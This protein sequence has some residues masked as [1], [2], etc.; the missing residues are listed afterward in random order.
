MA[1]KRVTI[2]HPSVH[3]RPPAVIVVT[4]VEDVGGPGLDRHGLGG[5]DVID[6]GGADRRIDRPVS[7]RVVDHVQLGA[8]GLGGEASPGA[9]GRQPHSGSIDQVGG[10]AQ[11]AAQ[12]TMRLPRH[13]REQIGKHRG[14]SQC[15]GIG[16]CRTPRRCRAKVIEPRRV[17]AQSR[18]DLAKAR[19][20]RKLC[21]QQRQQLAFRRQPP[22]PRVGPVDLDKSIERG[23][24]NMLLQIMKDA[25]LMPHGVVP[26]SCPITSPTLEHE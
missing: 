10:L 1:L 9:G 12:A 19:G 21:I 22:H 6:L 8:A 2:R 26:F 23:P 11:R 3:L 13:S 4:E 7:V 16:Q 14:R 25:I 5:G 24:R 18:L 15:V 17:A 20:T